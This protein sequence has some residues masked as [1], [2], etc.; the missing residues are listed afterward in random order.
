MSVIRYEQ[1]RISSLRVTWVLLGIM[2]VLVA[3]LA[4]AQA[5]LAN[6]D[7]FTGNRVGVAPMLTV[8]GTIADPIVLIP[9]AVLAAMAWGGEYKFG[10]AR[11]TFTAFPQRTKVYFAKLFTV[12]LWLIGFSLLGLAIVVLVA[13]IFRTNVNFEPANVDNLL[14]MAR[15]TAFALGFCLFGYALTAI[16]KSQAISIVLL[17]LWTILVETLL[18]GF[19]SSRVEWL[20]K[21]LPMSSGKNFL[22]GENMAMNAGVFFGYLAVFLVI[23]WIFVSRRDA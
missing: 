12:L 22:N 9:G 7:P 6:I 10:M 11:L 4:A 20:P 2:V 21:V 16:L 8:L 13:F 17:I 3:A 15:A 5:S 19:L 18:V 23:G 14:F 1:R